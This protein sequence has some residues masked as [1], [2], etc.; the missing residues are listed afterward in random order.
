LQVSFRRTTWTRSGGR[1][2]T[3]TTTTATGWTQASSPQFLQQP[4]AQASADQL[5]AYINEA[6]QQGLA[7]MHEQ[8]REQQWDALMT[9]YPDLQDPEAAAPVAEMI[10]ELAERAGNPDLVDDPR[11]ARSV[12]QMMR[13]G[14]AGDDQG[15]GGLDGYGEWAGRGARPGEARTKPGPG[16]IPPPERPRSDARRTPLKLRLYPTATHNSSSGEGG[17]RMQEHAH[18]L[19]GSRLS[20]RTAGEEMPAP[21]SPVWCG[22]AP[23]PR[24]ASGPRGWLR[25]PI[26]GFYPPRVGSPARGLVW[27]SGGRDAA[28][29]CCHLQRLH[30]QVAAECA[31][32]SARSGLLRDE[33]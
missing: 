8:A 7:P 6:V 16:G 12:V 5:R 4:P 30:D 31:T 13:S 29:A 32:V 17:E 20:S 25:L 19:Q 28:P 23:G 1:T 3:T 24:S 26:C 9:E 14:D 22:N 11:F 10:E 27:L 15:D 33:A 18:C 21:G 2:T